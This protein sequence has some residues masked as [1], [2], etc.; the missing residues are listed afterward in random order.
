MYLDW[1]TASEKNN[2]CFSIER[3]LDG[4]SFEEIKKIKSAGDSYKIINYEIIDENATNDILYYRLKQTDYNGQYKYSEI[5]SVDAYNT[6]C[7]IGNSFP[8]PTSSNVE[9]DFYTPLKG[10]LNYDILDYTGRVLLS[11]TQ[12]M[13]SG[14]S[15]LNAITDELPSGLYFLNVFFNK[16]HL[17]LV[18][19]IF[20][21]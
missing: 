9:I 7:L 2:D 14:H 4:F 17:T 13:E 6:K 16:T 1:K 19:N 11:K 3:S 15:K 18:H 10:E 20:K 8:N 21:N 5:V 12:I